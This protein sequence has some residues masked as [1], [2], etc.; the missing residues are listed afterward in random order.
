MTIEYPGEFWK[1]Y[2]LLDCGNF[3]KLER[4]GNYVMARPEPKALWDKSM[5]DEQWNKLIHTRFHTGAGFGKAGK[6]DSGTWERR[7]KTEDQWYIRYKGEQSGLDFSLRLGLTSFKHVG[8]FPEQSSNW[9]YIYRQTSELVKT[10]QQTGAPKPKVLN[11]F[12]Y[13]GAASLAA[14][15]AGA[16]VTHLDSVRQVVTW[17]RGNMESSG[18]DNIRWIVE[19]AL[20]FARREAKRGNIYQ[21]IILDPPAYGHGPDGEK[22]KLDECLNDMLKCVS[23]ILAPQDSFM[24]LNLYSNGFSAV[25]GETIVRQNFCQDT[26]FKSLDSGELVLK[27]SFGKLLPLSVVVRLRR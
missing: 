21:G 2:Q 18:L 20:K 10:A 24:V 9:E 7:R 23:S 8:V 22:W 15:A 3:E 17:A 25:L 4:F 14:K 12:A 1:D 11:L 16:D 26:A 5:S 13:T 6:E 19:D 27:D